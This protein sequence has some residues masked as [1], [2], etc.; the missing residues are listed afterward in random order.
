[1]VNRDLFEKLK[2][3]VRWE[4]I[5]D[6]RYLPWLEQMMKS[7]MKMYLRTCSLFA[8]RGTTEYPDVAKLAFVGCDAVQDC[9]VKRVRDAV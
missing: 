7:I 3:T 6:M 9:F 1:M 8:R 5:S 4:C 2:R